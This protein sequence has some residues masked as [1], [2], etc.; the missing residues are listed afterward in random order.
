MDSV[1]IRGVQ[2]IGFG[3]T[4]S[5]EDNCILSEVYVP[6]KIVKIKRLLLIIKILEKSLDGGKNEFKY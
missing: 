4:F 3:Q 5:N 2:N 1:Y 6:I